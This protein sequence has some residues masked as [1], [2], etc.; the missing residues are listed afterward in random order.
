MKGVCKVN[1]RFS[2]LVAAIAL[3]L[4][5]GPA[6]AFAQDALL[7]NVPFPFVASRMTHPAGEYRLRVSD[8]KSE[9]TITPMK[10]PATVALILSRLSLIDMPGQA[11]RAVF[12]RVGSTYFLSELW[13]PGEDGFLVHAAKEAHTHHTVKVG[14]TAK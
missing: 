11:D 1:H 9:L 13:L 7:I 10:G 14:R 8:N 3:V 4:A 2:V 6:R 5:V 12:D